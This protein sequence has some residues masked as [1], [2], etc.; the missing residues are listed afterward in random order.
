M[1]RLPPLLVRQ[2]NDCQ[3]LD[4]GMSA[5]NLLYFGWIDIL[6]AADN[7]I[8]LAVGEIIV[9]ILVATGHVADSTIRAAKR[10]NGPLRQLPIALKR[11]WR[12]RIKLTDFA[13]DHLVTF[14]VK[15]LD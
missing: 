1:N 12:A 8:T 4:L 7:H 13:V 3:I 11:V 6:P 15:E 9:A 5:K 14:R 2:A 10:L